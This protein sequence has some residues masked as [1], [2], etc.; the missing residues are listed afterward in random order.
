MGNMVQILVYCQIN[1]WMM[2]CW[3]RKMYVCLFDGYCLRYY[4]GHYE[5]S[6]HVVAPVDISISNRWEMPVFP[7]GLPIS[8]II[9]CYDFSQVLKVYCLDD[10]REKYPRAHLGHSLKFLK[11][12]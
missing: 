11:R 12:K 3:V 8:Y 7:P 2:N 10:P 4:E 1:S 9:K 6:F 5:V